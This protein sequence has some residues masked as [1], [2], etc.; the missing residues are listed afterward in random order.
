[1]RVLVLCHLSLVSFV[2]CPLS[3]SGG[4]S[5]R[6]GRCERQRSSGAAAPSGQLLDRPKLVS[7][8]F[9]FK[10]VFCRFS[11]PAYFLV[12]ASQGL[13]SRQG[14]KLSARFPRETL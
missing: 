5:A 10:S 8:K 14:S 9:K 1:P 6:D 13:G 7:V 2:P 11:C 12:I 3:R 4:T